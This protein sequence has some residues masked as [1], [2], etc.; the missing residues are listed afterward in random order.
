[1][2]TTVNPLT[3]EEA[4]VAFLL[5]DPDVSALAGRS[6][7]PEVG[8]DV[9][10]DFPRLTYEQ[11]GK[12]DDS[13]LTLSTDQPVIHLAIHAWAQGAGQGGGHDAAKALATAVRCARG[14][15]P[16]GSR[17][18]EFSNAWMPSAAARTGAGAVWVKHCWLDDE[19]TAAAQKAIGGGKK[20]VRQVASV[21]VLCFNE[22]LYG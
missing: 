20:W 2:A 18:K 22:N 15:N 1:M 14:S 16:L 9:P 10:G 6:I 5:A 11:I 7:Y 8:T 3:I 13:T 19:M 12:V 4:V 21:F 17:L